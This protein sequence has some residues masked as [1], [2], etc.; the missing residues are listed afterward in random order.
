M[1]PALNFSKLMFTRKG[2]AGIMDSQPMQPFS[3]VRGIVIDKL[4]I[5]V[6]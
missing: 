1:I 2:S 6:W 5:Q 4:L 3:K